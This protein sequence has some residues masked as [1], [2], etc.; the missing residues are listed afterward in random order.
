MTTE[1]PSGETF[2]AVKLI[3]LKNSSNVSLGLAVWAWANT[4]WEITDTREISRIDR[5]IELSIT[6]LKNYDVYT[7]RAVGGKRS[8]CTNHKGHKGARRKG[9]RQTSCPSWLWIYVA[10]T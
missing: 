4:E 10:T 8:H 7:A 9:S 2:T 1:L 5:P 6:V 3:E